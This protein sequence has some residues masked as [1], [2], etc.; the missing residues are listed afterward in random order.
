MSR[1]HRTG[2]GDIPY[3]MGAGDRSVLPSWARGRMG[4]ACVS[5]GA[6]IAG[7]LF[8]TGRPRQI[9]LPTVSAK[10]TLVP[11]ADPTTLA[12]WKRGALAVRV[13]ATG[14]VW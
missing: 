11:E 13:D 12:D 6:A 9:L 2:I 10:L 3:T 5:A 14:R 4:L 7:E 8:P 1:E